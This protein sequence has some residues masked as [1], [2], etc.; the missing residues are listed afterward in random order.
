MTTSEQHSIRSLN[1]HQSQFVDEEAAGRE[2]PFEAFTMTYFSDNMNH[3]FTG[4]FGVNRFTK[5]DGLKR[6]VHLSM[7]G[8]RFVRE[9][10]LILESALLLDVEGETMVILPNTMCDIGPGVPHMWRGIPSGTLLP[11]GDRHSGES[12]MVFFYQEEVRGFERVES[13]EI[14]TSTENLDSR[15]GEYA[16]PAVSA[17]E[18]SDLPFIHGG[19]L[20]YSQPQIA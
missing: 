7:D 1:I 9:R 13:A 2:E 12:I 19:T 6:H 17:D 20:K 4:Q 5:A 15:R 18:I 11:N 14:V 10:I 3:G 16:F 8:K